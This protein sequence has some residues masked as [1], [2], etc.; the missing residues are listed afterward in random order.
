MLPSALGRDFGSNGPLWSLAYEAVYYALYP[1]WLKLR[2]R[3]GPAAYMAVMGV[4]CGALAMPAGGFL[5]Q[6][7]AHYLLWIAGAGLAELTCANRLSRAAARFAPALFAFGMLASVASVN[8]W[9]RLLANSAIG[10]GAVVWFGGGISR[11]QPKAWFRLWEQLGLRSYTIYICHFPLLTL[12]S[13]CLLS[14]HGSRPLHGWVALLGGMTVLGLCLA[15]FEMCE[16]HFLH[17]RIRV[18]GLA[19]AGKASPP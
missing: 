16:R 1:L 17:A 15:A 19:Y 18:S 3:N 5:S 4:T 14:D 10:A 8:P 9:M 7:L 2:E 11:W 6:V 12:I 13:A